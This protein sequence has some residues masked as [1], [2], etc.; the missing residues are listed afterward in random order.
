MKEILRVNMNDDLFLMGPVFEQREQM[1]RKQLNR[2]KRSLLRKRMSANLVVDLGGTVT[3]LPTINSSPVLSGSIVCPGSGTTIGLSAD[4]INA[5]T[6]CN[7]SV[8]GVSASGQLRL[9]VQCSDTDTSGNYTD[10]TSGLAILPRDFASGG[11]IWINSGG[12]LG[13]VLGGDVSQFLTGSAPLSGQPNSGTA[14]ASGFTRYVAFQRPTRFARVNVLSEAAAQ[15]G[16]ALQVAFVSQTK[17]T[18]SGGGASWQPQGSG[19]PFV[20]NV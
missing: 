3:S 11:L 5:D 20:V 6:F 17:T 16:G 10:P 4:L 19:Q 1:S 9:Q 12:S 15:Y 18:G 8:A 13:A 2:T 7:I 14:I